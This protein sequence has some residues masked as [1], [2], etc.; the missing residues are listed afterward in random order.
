MGFVLLFSSSLSFLQ[1]IVQNLHKHLVVLPFD[2]LRIIAA[3]FISCRH[4]SH[5]IWVSREIGIASPPP[6]FWDVRQILALVLNLRR[7]ALF[8]SELLGRVELL[9]RESILAPSHGIDSP[10]WVVPL[11]RDLCTRLLLEKPEITVRLCLGTQKSNWGSLE[12]NYRVIN[13]I[14]EVVVVLTVCMLLI[15]W[16]TLSIFIWYPVCSNLLLYGPDVWE[17][18]SDLGIPTLAALSLST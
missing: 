18:R 3:K 9:L 1:V 7:H 15:C 4:G 13:V 5:I 8:R 16:L 14:L 2:T 17:R 12:Q 10:S 11:S 6:H